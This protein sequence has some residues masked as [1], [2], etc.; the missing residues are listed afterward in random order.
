MNNVVSVKIST[1]YVIGTYQNYILQ[2][3]T[4]SL[5]NQMSWKQFKIIFIL[6]TRCLK[7]TYV[8]V[9]VR[10]NKPNVIPHVYVLWVMDIFVF[11][12]KSLF[13]TRDTFL[14]EM[15]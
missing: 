3:S 14:T 1:P 11:S 5:K 4:Q 7:H 2:I 15:L 13:V 6:Y 8:L 12:T 10:T 9:A